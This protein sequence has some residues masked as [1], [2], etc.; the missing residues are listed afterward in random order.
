MHTTENK[1]TIHD[2]R[3]EPTQFFITDRLQLGEIIEQLTEFTGK[4]D[5]QIMS[6]SVGEEFVRKIHT[7]KKKGRIKHAELFFDLKPQKRQHEQIHSQ[8]PF[9]TESAIVPIMQKWSSWTAKNKLAPS[10]HRKTGREAQETRSISLQTRGKLQNMCEENWKNSELLGS[11]LEIDY[12]LFERLVRALTPIADIAVLMD[13]DEAILRDNI[14]DPNTP[15]SKAF[16]RIRAQTA[17]E[18]R[19]RNI[20]YME[21]G[22]PSATEKVSEFLK[23]A[24]LDL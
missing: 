9:L 20:E 3:E 22:S 8:Q 17:L 6:F 7:L 1:P 14:E 5:L 21:A 15:V 18:I 2:P 11:I 24:F 10:S 4:A 23:Q 12:E 19:E 13:V 16:R